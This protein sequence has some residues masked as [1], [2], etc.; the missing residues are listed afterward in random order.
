MLLQLYPPHSN[1]DLFMSGFKDAL[2]KMKNITVEYRY[3]ISSDYNIIILKHEDTDKFI[4]SIFSF[5]VSD[6]STDQIL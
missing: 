5:F 1:Y 4:N 6:N 2:N 3:I